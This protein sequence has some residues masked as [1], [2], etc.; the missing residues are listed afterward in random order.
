MKIHVAIY[1]T[2]LTILL[3]ILPSATANAQAHDICRDPVTKKYGVCY[4]DTIRVPQ[5]YDFGQYITSFEFILMK[6]N[7][8]GVVDR[9]GNW[10]IEMIYD[11]MW[12]FTE[13]P[14]ELLVKQGEKY[15]IINLKGK[16]IVPLYELQAGE[17]NT[18]HIDDHLSFAKK[19]NDFQVIQDGKMAVYNMQGKKIFDFIYPFVQ[20]ILV[21]PA[22]T[23]KPSYYIF[24]VGSDGKYSF[25]DA[26]NKPI[27]KDIVVEDMY[28]VY[29]AWGSHTKAIKR[30]GKIGFINIETGTILSISE[31]EDMLQPF[32]MIQNLE[33]K[34]GAIDMDG[35]TR[36]PCIY[37]NMVEI[38]EVD[39]VI[40]ELD[41]KKGMI[42]LDGEI[43]LE[44]KYEFVAEICFDGMDP[45][46]FPYEVDNGKY[47]AI[48]TYDPKTKKMIQKTDFKYSDVT[49]FEVTKEGLKAY[50][51]DSTGKK[52]LLLPDGSIQMNK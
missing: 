32:N 52:G 1:T 10:I 2:L 33:D 25:V 22:D 23:K 7:K 30:N 41:G 48:F 27:F 34:M 3:V 20:D 45:T 16:V 47:I 51:T 12:E 9:Y 28:S 29:H 42:N 36:V 26:K 17:I 21:Q 6:D 13:M 24:L 50:L 44:P 49:C 8:Y 4:A 40:V 14:N 46:L 11:H 5:I 18:F 43:L 37:N 38:P 31:M 15:G 35:N 39:Y 19:E